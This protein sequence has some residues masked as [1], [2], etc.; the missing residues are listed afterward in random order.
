MIILDLFRAV[1]SGDKL[2]WC[3]AWTDRIESADLLGRNRT[4]LLHAT[5]VHPFDIAFLDG[6]FY[7][8]DWEVPG[9][10]RF[11][12]NATFE[13]KVH[14]SDSFQSPAGLHVYEGVSEGKLGNDL[15]KRHLNYSFRYG[16]N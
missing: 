11:D 12:P 2:Y 8:T 6:I 16:D 7:W 5:D 14:G 9:V 10:V 15:I 13:L 1:F 3:D 4:V